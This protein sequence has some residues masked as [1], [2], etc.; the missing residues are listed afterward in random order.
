MRSKIIEFISFL[1]IIL[2]FILMSLSSIRITYG[3]FSLDSYSNHLIF[4]GVLSLITYIISK[5]KNFKFNKY[6]IIVFILMILS[7]LSLINAISIDEALFG[8]YGRYEGLFVILSY[9]IYILIGMNIKN[10]KYLK[11]IISFIILIG[12]INVFYGLLQ[13][14]IIKNFFLVK[15]KWIYAR[16]FLGNSMFYGTLMSICYPLVLGTFLKTDNIINKIISYILV[17]I[18][19]LG[20]VISGNMSS[21]VAVIFTFLL[22]LFDSLKYLIK[23]NKDGLYQVLLFIFS[24]I[25]FVTILLF[26]TFFNDTLKSDLLE[27]KNETTSISQ[28]EVKEDFGTGR[29]YIWKNTILKIKEN[30]YGIGID[31]FY[32]AFYP[33]LIDSRSGFPVD[34][35][36]ND[37]LQKMLCEGIIPGTLFIILLLIIFFKNLFK[38]KNNL[39]YGLFLAFTSYSI[40]AFFNISMTRVAPIYFII[41]GLLIS[42]EKDKIYEN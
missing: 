16:G 31:N 35:A 41:M 8:R 37:Y 4:L 1:L 39:N 30:P 38:H 22:I 11:I 25:S 17:L 2:L 10:K 23:K 12:L 7:S 18:F 21:Y 40:Q 13:V 15:N 20:V 14:D 29:I 26:I 27:F 42:Q 28:G 19:S 5:I 6:E 9:Y 36:H 33:P 3:T 24:I 32:N 34:K